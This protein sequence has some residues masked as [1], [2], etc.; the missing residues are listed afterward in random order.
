MAADK[1]PGQETQ[2]KSAFGVSGSPETR[3][4]RWGLS[5]EGILFKIAKV[6]MNEHT[7]I[8]WCTGWA[9]DGTIVHAVSPDMLNV[10]ESRRLDEKLESAAKYENLADS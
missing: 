9:S 4:N 6:E 1:S 8:W 5:G 3:I 2:Y 7:G 10:A